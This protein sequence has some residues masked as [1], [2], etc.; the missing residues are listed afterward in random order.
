MK[1]KQFDAVKMMRKIRNRLHRR[2]AANRKLQEKDLEKIR[3]QRVEN[4]TPVS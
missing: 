4:T 3:E 2:Y 1:T